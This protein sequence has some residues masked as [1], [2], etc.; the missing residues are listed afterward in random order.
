VGEEELL[1]R[2]RAPPAPQPSA[3]TPQDGPF[4]RCTGNKFSPHLPLMVSGAQHT[5][6]GL[7]FQA[8]LV[9]EV[10]NLCPPTV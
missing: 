4:G 3:D 7:R 8:L 2:S 5:M 10:L 6:S 1:E 9:V